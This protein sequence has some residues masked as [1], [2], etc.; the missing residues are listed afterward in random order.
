MSTTAMQIAHDH[1]AFAGHFPGQPLLPGVLLLAQVLEAALADPALAGR[2]GDAPR[3]SSAKFLSPVRPGDRIEMSFDTAATGT[4][5][6]F[7][8]RC[9]DKLAAAGQF[10]STARSTSP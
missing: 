3:L 8:V 7:E 1:P 10:E 9:G 4:R 2:L 5:L 6:G